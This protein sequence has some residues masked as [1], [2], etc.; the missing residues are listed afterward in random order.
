[1]SSQKDRP[2]NR[3]APPP[4]A[5]LAGT[6]PLGLRTLGQFTVLSAWHLGATN[7]VVVAVYSTVAAAAVGIVGHSIHLTIPWRAYP[8]IALGAAV[9]ILT[10]GRWLALLR[11]KLRAWVVGYFDDNSVLLVLPHRG[12]W[13][14]TDHVTKHPGTGEAS[15]FRRAVFSHLATQADLHQ[16]AIYIETFTP[17]LVQAYIRDMP[18]L[19]LHGTRRD[20]MA[21]TVHMLLRDCVAGCANSRH[22][23]VSW[24]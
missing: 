19:R 24:R 1:M 12:R 17:K 8:V 20:W 18:D 23:P 15:A 4:P 9:F 13:M 22:L 7:W 10:I 5:P 21:R 3:S 6:R 16:V 2:V 11:L 14:L